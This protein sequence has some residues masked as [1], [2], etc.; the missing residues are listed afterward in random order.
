MAL[1]SHYF[2]ASSTATAQADDGNSV[3][4]IVAHPEFRLTAPFGKA[5]FT[6]YIRGA[7]LSS[8]ATPSDFLIGVFH[9]T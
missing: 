1:L 5:L 9:H 8:F 2:I 7:M 4:E 6:L 3:R